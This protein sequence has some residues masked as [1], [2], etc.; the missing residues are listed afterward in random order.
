MRSENSTKD[1][2][3]LD[4]RGE[5]FFVPTLDDQTIAAVSTPLGEGGIGI[6]RL[7]GNQAIDIADKIFRGK[8]R[9]V[10]LPSQSIHYG[11]IVHPQSLEVIDTV[12]LSV[13][14][15]P[16]SYTREDV[17]EINGHGGLVCL[18]KILNLV[19]EQGSRLAEPGEFT[20]RAFLNGRIDLSQAEAVLDVIRAKT[21]LSMKF[22]L[23]QLEGRLGQKILAIKEDLILL[24]ANIEACLDFLEEE[25]IE[26]ISQTE[27]LEI[28]L[29]IQAQITELLNS[30]QEGQILRQGIT[31][32]IIGRPNV[33][34]SSLL[35][36]L[37]GR[38]R[39]IVTHLPGTTRDLLEEMIDLDGIPIKIVDTA[40]LRHTVEIVEREGVKR[41]RQALDAADLI[42]L[43]LDSS[44]EL[45]DED[46]AILAELRDK[47]AIIILNKADLPVVT[48]PEEI[49]AVSPDK[50][51]VRISA[52]LESGL[53]E[54]KHTIKGMFF[55]GKF[56]TS[57]GLLIT[58]LRHKEALKKAS[59]SMDKA[60]QA[61]KDNLSLEFV[62]LDLRE[63]LDSLGLIIGQTV[64]EDILAEI[65]SCFCIGK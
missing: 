5:N 61:L 50:K 13:M 55:S 62:S 64:T 41:A 33:G 52:L 12:L 47:K 17:V 49:I 42:L 4:G 35:N 56:I 58:N 24:L 18:N 34:K 45:G 28:A 6:V 48:H 19:L 39:A 10:D 63:A 23:S 31:T 59:Q 43:V 16:K 29:N 26:P 7:S 1:E 27:M 30:A 37:L 20:K 32:T 21:D 60:L 3:R 15:A 54:L 11:Q 46:K 65:F 36:A 8:Q 57:E 44:K 51:I 9:V 2:D 53:D 14:R 25:E 40:G 38:P 22:S